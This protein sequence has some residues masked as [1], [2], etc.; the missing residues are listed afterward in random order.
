MDFEIN[1]DVILS[2][3]V[4]ANSLRSVSFS[5]IVFQTRSRYNPTYNICILFEYRLLP[6]GQSPFSA[7]QVA[8]KFR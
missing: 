5:Y 8:I 6:K 7:F 2:K 3:F 1:D 4:L